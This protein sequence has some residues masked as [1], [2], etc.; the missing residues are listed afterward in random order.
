MGEDK[1]RQPAYEK[2][3]FYQEICELRKRISEITKSFPR[4]NIRLISQ[5]KDAA[6][7]AKQNIREGYRKGSAGEFEHSIRIS[8]GSLEE[9]AGDVEDSLEDG[10]ITK[11]QRDNIVRLIN[12]ATYLS[13][14]Y[15]ISLRKMKL[16]N[17]WKK[18]FVE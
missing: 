7:S 11:E 4:E 15:I 12:S 13:G 3:K 17:K 18:P 2:L 5:M 1:G 14:R 10:L 16:E 6:R 8:Q 9:L